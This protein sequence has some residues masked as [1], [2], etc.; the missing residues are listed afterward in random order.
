MNRH[1]NRLCN[2]VCHTPQSISVNRVPRLLLYDPIKQVDLLASFESLG[3]SFDPPWTVTLAPIQD[4]PS[5]CSPGCAAPQCT[6][7]C[8]PVLICHLE[9]RTLGSVAPSLS[10][11]PVAFDRQVRDEWRLPARHHF[12]AIMN[13]L[14]A[15]D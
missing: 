15:A 10:I 2:K 11:Q 1:K 14:Y 6:F 13:S 8:T 7:Y 3:N 5:T 12:R 4:S 9:W